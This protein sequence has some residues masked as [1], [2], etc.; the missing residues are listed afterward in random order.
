[1]KV[2]AKVVTELD[3]VTLD[4]AAKEFGISR[5]T[6]QRLMR[7]GAISRYVRTGDRRAYVDR[8]ELRDVL[9]LRKEPPPKRQRKKP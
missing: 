6:V 5:S 2:W 7:E 4:V 9:T 8:D 1:M 3:P